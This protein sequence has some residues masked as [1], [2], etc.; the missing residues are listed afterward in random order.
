MDTTQLEKTALRR[1]L[2]AVERGLTAAEKQASDTAIIRHVLSAEEYRLARTVFAFVGRGREIDTMPLLRQ[3]LA[4]GKRLCVPLCTGKGIM[5]CRQVRDLS[6]LR[7]GAYGIPEPP[8]DAPEVARADID[9][10]I[11][12]CVG[13]SPEGWRLGRGGG[14]YDRFLARYTGRALLLCRRALLRPD[15]PRQPHDIRIPAVITEQ[16]RVQAGAV[17]DTAGR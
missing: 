3:I 4:D 13:A 17:P 15:I 8:A 14:Y 10:S 11:V 7:P 2:T 12:P 5:E 16:G 6:I 1:T 9:L